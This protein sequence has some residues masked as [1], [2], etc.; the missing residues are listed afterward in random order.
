MQFLVC[1][2]FFLIPFPPSTPPFFSILRVLKKDVYLLNFIKGAFYRR[3]C[4]CRRCIAFVFVVD[5]VVFVVFLIKSINSQLLVITCLLKEIVL[6]VFGIYGRRS[7][8][9]FSYFHI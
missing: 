4:F 2:L 7:F 8:L 6:I 9:F 1:F 3:Y 5:V